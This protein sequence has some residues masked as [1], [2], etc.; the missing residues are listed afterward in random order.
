LLLISSRHPQNFNVESQEI[1]HTVVGARRATAD[2]DIH[3]ACFCGYDVEATQQS[4]QSISK[5]VQRQ[6]KVPQSVST[7]KIILTV[8]F[9]YRGVL[10]CGFVP[11]GQR[12][13]QKCCL[14]VSR[15]LRETVCKEQRKIRRQ[16]SSFLAT[17]LP[18][19]RHFSS[20]CFSRKIEQCF[21]SHSTTLMCPQPPSS[22]SQN[23]ELFWKDVDFFSRVNSRR[24]PWNF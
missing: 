21:H 3:D 2:D 19:R 4:S 17:T 12:V 22:S 24:N 11:R 20:K 6:N 14:S 8:F 15:R 9:D 10:H 1:C 18:R 23:L 5:S 16:R 7:G 13:N